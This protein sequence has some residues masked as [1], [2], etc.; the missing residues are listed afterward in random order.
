[1]SNIE[2]SSNL[3]VQKKKEKK[4]K[5]K[6]WKEKRRQIQS[7]AQTITARGSSFSLPGYK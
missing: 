2:F 3:G 1:M 6:K 4:R 7:I 5:K